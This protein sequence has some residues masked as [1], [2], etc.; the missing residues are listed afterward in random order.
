M[1]IVLNIVKSLFTVFLIVGLLFSSG[2]FSVLLYAKMT[3]KEFFAESPPAVV[4]AEG[5]PDQAGQA[6]QKPPEP[7]KPKPASA[8]LDAPVVRQLPELPAG[9]EIVSLTM[10]LN[11]YGID[12]G[13]MELF[14]EMKKDP[15]PIRWEKGAIAYWGHPNTGYVGDATGKSR[16]FGIYHAAL[17]DTLKAYVPTAKDLTGSAFDAVERQIA[18]GYP[19]VVWTTIDFAVPQKWVSWDT[20]VGPIETTFMEHAV[21]LV[22]YDE[23]H[24][25]VNDPLSGKKAH[26]LN[27]DQFLATWDAM[28]KQALSY[29]K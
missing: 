14:G 26:K 22:G 23:T 18:D 21:L 27:K 3:G 28:G 11:Y 15:T 12:K 2:V 7:V 25:F 4:L 19:V 5:A 29:V 13:K 16:G 1:M 8:M 17:F 20:P 24:V 10:L 9:C 6:G